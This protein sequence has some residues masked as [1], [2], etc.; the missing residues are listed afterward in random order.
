MVGGGKT[1][2]PL[3]YLTVRD[4]AALRERL[5]ALAGAYRRRPAEAAAAPAAAA[6]ARPPWNARCYAVRNRDLVISQLLTPQAF[7]LPFGVA[8]VVDAVRARGRLDLHRHRQHDHRDGRRAAAAGPAGAAGLGLPA[9][10]RRRRPAAGALRPAGDPQP[11]RA[12]RTGCSRSARPGRC[13]GA[14]K[15]WLHLRLDVAG[16]RRRRSRATTSAPTG[17]C[18]SATSRPPGRWSGRCCPASTWTALPTTPPPRRARWLHPFALRLLGA[19]LTDRGVR[20]PLGPADPRAVAGAVRAAAERAGGAG[21]AAA[22]AAAWPRCTRTPPAAGPAR[23]GTATS[24][25]RGR[26]PTQ[27][28]DPGPAGPRPGAAR[29]PTRPA[30]LDARQ[31][32]RAGRPAVP[33]PDD[34]ATGGGPPSLKLAAWSFRSSPPVSAPG[35]S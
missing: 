23:P 28:A 32:R 19:G 30:P 10:P 3:A 13:S 31:R 33:A 11:G 4:A 35:S 17:C 22:P 20:D 2:A 9:G 8:F 1:E 24:P 5:L 21:P 18:R 7:F 12:A 27:L 26:W 14:R 6:P 15:G 25:R 29:A 16:V 34:D